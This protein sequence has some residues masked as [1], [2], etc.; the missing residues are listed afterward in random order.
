MEKKYKTDKLN[1]GYIGRISPEKN[2][3]KMINAVSILIDKGR[4]IHFS[5][6]GDVRDSDYIESVNK[7]ILSKNLSRNVKLM[8]QT[9]KVVEAYKEIDLIILISDYEGFSNVIAEALTSG[10]PIITSAIPENE[11]LVS[12]S[13]NGFTVNHKDV[14]S[15]VNGIE[16]FINLPIKNKQKISLNN[17]RKSEEIFDNEKLYNQYLKLIKKV[18]G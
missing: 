14:L 11:Y 17:R 3:L 13:I 4:E 9:N 16:K 7:L 6:Y 1:L 10:L 18:I 15:I 8:G 5:I 12:D 2:I